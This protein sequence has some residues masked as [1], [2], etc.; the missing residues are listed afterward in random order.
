M[1]AESRISSQ[2][3]NPYRDL[4]PSEQLGLPDAVGRH[5]R[6]LDVLVA[7][8]LVGKGGQLYHCL[9]K[10]RLFDENTAFP[11]ELAVAA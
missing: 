2:L 11:T 3:P 4:Q 8:D 1:L 6:H 5:V 10:R 9:Q 7:T